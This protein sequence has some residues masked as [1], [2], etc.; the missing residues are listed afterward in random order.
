MW[1]AIA[2]LEFLSYEYFSFFDFQEV[3]LG[4]KCLRN[5]KI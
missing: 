3:N 4:E 5:R 2:P 1:K